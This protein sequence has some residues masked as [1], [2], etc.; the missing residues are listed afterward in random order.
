MKA[1]RDA[2]ALLTRAER[3]RALALTLLTLLGAAAEAL[4]IGLIFPFISLLGN[5]GP[6][7]SNPM[8]ARVYGW[9]GAATLEEFVLM[10]A[11]ALIGVYL[12]K[13][14]FLALLYAWQARFVAGVE[15]RLS[16]DLLAAYMY[17]P[18]L[19]RLNR[20]SSDQLR[21]ITAEVGRATAGFI[22]PVIA[23]LTE[24]LVLA[25]IATLLLIVQPVVTLAAFGVIGTSA[26]VLLTV[27]RRKVVEQRDIRTR[28]NVDMFKWASQGMGALKETKVLGREEHFVGSF[29]SASRDYARSTGLFNAMNLMPRLAVEAVAVCS[30]L[31]IVAI[32]IVLQQ[33]MDQLLPMLMLF[34][35][36]AVRVMPSATR[37]VGAVNNVRYYAT[38][39]SAVA[40]DLQS[41]GTSA[42]D[43]HALRANR[44]R[45]AFERLEL[46]N[47]SFRYPAAARPGLNDVTLS[48]RRG[49]MIA[50][51]GRSGSGKTTLGDVILGLLAPQGGSV[52]VNG[53]RIDSLH[54]ECPG[55]SALVPQD[56]FLLDDSV[57]RN[58]AFGIP[59][60]EIDDERVWEALRLAQ[61]DS[62]VRNL[63]EGLLA[64]VGERGALLSG[65]ERQRLSI[66]R[67]LYDDPD[68]LL[69]D[70][71]T[72]ALDAATETE[73]VE[74]LRS[75]AGH[76]T[77]LLITHRLAAAQRCER[78]IMMENAAV[79]H[80]APPTAAPIAPALA[81]LAGTAASPARI[82]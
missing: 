65:G 45:R 31:A 48:I 51:V 49:E 2:W 71:A 16:V 35:L 61:L 82:A 5:P 76:K 17:A 38:A 34:G 78:V 19:A 21:M 55:M 39:V 37:I 30:L 60:A 81:G 68:I 53:E 74:T 62:R 12:A 32:A 18:Y 58:V 44:V 77:V 41:A 6:V 11:L 7:V 42:L 3:W 25:A 72:S 73:I 43:T 75:L 59:D 66:A 10:G 79:L 80:D 27:F 57:R 28:S 8:F 52:R 22:M 9:S 50:I 24:G 64:L 33:R 14:L 20:N 26:L 13:N 56:F 4:G 69:L 1:L 23:L 36:A 54:D 67:A 29:A 15:A 46:E 70:E 63:P 47:V 40:A